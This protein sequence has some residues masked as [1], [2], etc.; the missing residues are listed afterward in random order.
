[1]T[2]RFGCQREGRGSPEGFSV[3]EGIGGGDKMAAS[4]S[5]GHRRG[6]SGLGGSTWRCGAWGGVEMV[7]GGLKWAVRSGS[8]R[9]EMNGVG[10]AEEQPRA[11]ARRSRELPALVRSSGRCRGV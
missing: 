4:W 3:V 10:G 7:E 11:P 6:L 1:V 5:R 8:G 9:P 2:D